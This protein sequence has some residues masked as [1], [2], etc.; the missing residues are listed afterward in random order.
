MPDRKEHVTR[1]TATP[2]LSAF[3]S[4]LTGTAILVDPGTYCYISDRNRARLV[5]RHRART[6]RSEST[7]SI[8]P[9]LMVSFAWSSIPNVRAETWVNGRTFD[10]F[11][12]SH[13]GYRRLP[14][15]VLHRRSVFT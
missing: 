5:S 9:F 11:V 8:K 15:P 4:P 6:I 1:A 2:T 12:G 14:D 3:A 10:F 13:D 7:T